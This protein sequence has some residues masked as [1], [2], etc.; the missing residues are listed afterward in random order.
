MVGTA[1]WM[2]SSLSLD[3]YKPQC[4]LHSR[5]CFFPSKDFSPKGAS[6]LASH[7]WETH[8]GENIDL[9]KKKNKQERSV[10]CLDALALVC[11]PHS[12]LTGPV[13]VGMTGR[14]K[15]RATVLPGQG[16]DLCGMTREEGL[17]SRGEVLHHHQ[18]TAAIYQPSWGKQQRAFHRDLFHD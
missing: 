4:S 14:C 15:S 8:L 16:G 2:H 18:T 9:K 1:V 12:D 11:I 5:P 7:C 3:S 6:G 13:M 10:S 17:V